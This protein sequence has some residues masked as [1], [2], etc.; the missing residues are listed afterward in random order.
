VKVSAEQFAEVMGVAVEDFK[1]M[2]SGDPAGT[3]LSFF[4]GLS[5]GDSTVLGV[6]SSLELTEVRLSSLIAA[7]AKNPEFFSRMLETS[8]KAWEENAALAEATALAYGTSESQT[9]LSL[10]KVEN[11]S[12]DVGENIIDVLQPV[13]ETVGNLAEE[14]GKLDE[15][16]QSNWVKI[17]GA[18]ILLGPAAMGIGNVATS[19]GKMV[20]WLGK[21]T[22]AGVSNWTNMMSA[23]TGLF[24]TPVGGVL[25]I[26]TTVAGIIALI[27]TT[28]NESVAIKEN[29][30]NIKVELDQTSY[31]E[32]M[33][34][35]A[36][37][38]AQSD[39]LSGEAG[40]QNRNVSAAVKAGYGTA[41]MY[42]TALGYEA[43][44]TQKTISEIAGKYAERIN[45]LNSAIGAETDKGQQDLLAAQRDTLQQQWNSE[46]QAA[47]DSYTE[48]VSALVSGMMQAQPEAKA[49]LE[50]AAKDYDLLSIVKDIEAEALSKG[51][52]DE[53]ID[54]Y[55][56]ILTPDVFDRFFAGQTFESAIGM[57][58]GKASM[59][60]G[61]VIENL[62]NSM[63]SALE[64]AGGEESLAYTLWQT[65]LGDPTTSNLFDQTKTKGPLDGI[66][67]ALDYNNA[68]ETAGKDWGDA[69]TTGLADELT[70][71]TPLIVAP[72]SAGMAEAV[73]AA[74][75]T[76]LGIQSPSTVFKQHGLDTALGIQLGILQGIPLAGSAMST[77]GAALTAIAS[78]Q[79]A[80]AGNAYGAAFS[81]NASFQLSIAI[82]RLKQELSQL[83]VRISRGYGKI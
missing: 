80:S 82:N 17:G 2:W 60:A 75:T 6:L 18:L 37:L 61:F 52:G 63:Y 49:A 10:N 46:T 66:I 45:E 56:K 69:L 31:D 15:T 39:A 47:R 53:M 25:A 9:S 73:D 26:G 23:L 51:S 29:L 62:K 3:M 72:A 59:Y 70:A 21:L 1:T 22:P 54:V 34:A 27:D 78:A 5:K 16:T 11:A 19:I 35:L 8:D 48:A 64:T 20:G 55:K 65:I 33:K 44:F 81:R 71:Q 7:A 32:S 12:A 68:G 79:G 4:D 50:Q 58:P 77:L 83:E 13:I 41:D 40:E 28:V 57:D 24:S 76:P 14:F 36:D 67:E 43:A 38:K 74:F 42:G 30:S